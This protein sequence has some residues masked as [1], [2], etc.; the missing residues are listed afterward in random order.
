MNN[1]QNIKTFRRPFQDLL[2]FSSDLDRL[3]W[4]TQP[5]SMADEEENVSATWA[6][7]V[8]IV[9]D[10]DAVKL[11]VELPGLEK[12]D[13][14]IHISEGILTLK[15]EKKMTQE[16]KKDRYYRLERSYGMFVRSFSLPNIIDAENVQASMKDGVLEIVIPKLPEAKPKQIEIQGK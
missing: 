15:G 7:A 1:L 5:S 10:A 11:Q 3:F 8:D 2:R 9:E 6:P 4:G 14:S 16:Q 12:K 13:V